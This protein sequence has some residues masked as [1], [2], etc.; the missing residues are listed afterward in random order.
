MTDEQLRTLLREHQ[1]R[2]FDPRGLVLH[3]AGWCL[4][5]QFRMGPGRTAPEALEDWLDH[6]LAVAHGTRLEI[7]R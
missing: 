5:R 1:L 4:C 6:M 7:A 3:S 2:D